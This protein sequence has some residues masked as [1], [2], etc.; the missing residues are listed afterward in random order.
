M[1][2]LLLFT[3]GPTTEIVKIHIFGKQNV[4]SSRPDLIF[5]TGT[6]SRIY[7]FNKTNTK[8]QPEALHWS[9]K[10]CATTK[11]IVKS[12]NQGAAR[13]AILIIWN[14]ISSLLTHIVRSRSTIVVL[15]MWAQEWS[16]CLIAISAAGW[17]NGT[18]VVL[19]IRIVEWNIS[20]TWRFSSRWF[21]CFALWQS[22]SGS[23]SKILQ[24]F[25]CAS[26]KDTVLTR[27]LFFQLFCDV[28]HIGHNPQE[29]SRNV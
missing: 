19:T 9:K 1:G 14:E 17:N 13:T 2:F 25:V 26:T 29:E 10:D 6:R 28:A 7:G 24:P 12:Q 3:C 16:I 15:M 8:Q 4:S 27:V 20:W 5:T 21:P 22:L 11:V 18:N 23:T